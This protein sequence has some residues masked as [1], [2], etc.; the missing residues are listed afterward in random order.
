MKDENFPYLN[1]KR[2]EIKYEFVVAKIFTEIK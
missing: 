2:E 1:T